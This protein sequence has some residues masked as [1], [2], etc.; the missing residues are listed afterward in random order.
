MFSFLV[1]CRIMMCITIKGIWDYIKCSIRLMQKESE[2]GSPNLVCS[3]PKR[4]LGTLAIS[5]FHIRHV[6]AENSS[7]SFLSPQPQVYVPSWKMETKNYEGQKMLSVANL[8]LFIWERSPYPK[9]Y[10]YTL[11][12]MIVSWPFRSSREARGQVLRV[13]PSRGWQGSERVVGNDGK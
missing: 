12:I 1:V 2:A 10:N 8:Y 11:L 5:I 7:S 4:L 9:T 3:S 13:I 6:E